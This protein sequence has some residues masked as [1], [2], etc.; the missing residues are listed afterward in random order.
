MGAK[1]KRPFARAGLPL[2]ID[3]IQHL[4][5]VGDVLRKLFRFLT[6][7]V[8]FH[9]SFQRED[10]I[11]CAETDVFVQSFGDQR[12]LVVLLDA[13]IQVGSD[14]L[15]LR[16]QSHGLNAHFVYYDP[17]SSIGL[18]YVGGLLFRI[19][20]MHFAFQGDRIL[21]SVFLDVYVLQIGLLQCRLDRV[22]IVVPLA[23][24]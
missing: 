1:E 5:Y 14:A 13:V 11:L 17:I 22:L 2:H 12:G 18:G 24:L 6:L 19:L 16:L 7:R 15:G 3:F 23:L 8:G 9:F 20:G 4:L 10:A 21:V